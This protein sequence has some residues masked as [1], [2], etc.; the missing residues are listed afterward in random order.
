[1]A[2]RVLLQSVATHFVTPER[3]RAAMVHD[4]VCHK[5]VNA[6]AVEIGADDLSSHR[7]YVVDVLVVSS[8]L[9]RSRSRPVATC[10]GIV[11]VVNGPLTLS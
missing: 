1:M 8:R 11:F 9:D 6:V 4:D 7:Q 3:A 5:V 10:G 2:Y